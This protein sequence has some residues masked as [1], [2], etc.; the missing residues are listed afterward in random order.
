M[1]L[2]LELD[3]AAV[4]TIIAGL[5]ELPAKQSYNLITDIVRQVQAQAAPPPDTAKQP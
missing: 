3:K 5:G 2:K 4:D 1:N